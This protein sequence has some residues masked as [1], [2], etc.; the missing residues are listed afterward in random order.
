MNNAVE[1]VGVALIVVAFGL[2]V[3]SASFVGWWLAV[4]V[5]GVACLVSGVVLVL[6]AARRSVT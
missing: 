3:A 2:C 4:L 5:A 1:I 6:T